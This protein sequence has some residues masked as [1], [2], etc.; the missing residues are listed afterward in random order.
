MT[1]V[2]LGSTHGL[3]DNVELLVADH[4]LARAVEFQLSPSYRVGEQ[5]EVKLITHA[6]D[7]NLRHLTLPLHPV[8]KFEM[9]GCSVSQ[10]PT[11]LGSTVLIGLPVHK[12]EPSPCA[13]RL[14]MSGEHNA[15]IEVKMLLD[16]NCVGHWKLTSR[17]DA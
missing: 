6:E 11:L 14:W 12:R 16:G 1:N 15:V 8:Y 9:A 13:C 5:V 17:R 10:D 3:P 2:S 7:I 4:P